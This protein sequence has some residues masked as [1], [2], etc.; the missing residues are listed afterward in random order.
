MGELALLAREATRLSNRLATIDRLLNA[1]APITGNGWRSKSSTGGDLF[2]RAATPRP[3][4]KRQPAA[5]FDASWSIFKYSD[6]QPRVPAGQHGGGQWTS[7]DGGGGISVRNE[8]ARERARTAI[9]VIESTVKQMKRNA[10]ADLGTRFVERVKAALG[11]LE[12]FAH[13]R[14]S[15]LWHRLLSIAAAAVHAVTSSID[16]IGTAAG[17][18]TLVGLTLGNAPVGL[19]AAVTLGGLLVWDKWAKRAATN[20]SKAEAAATRIRI[21]NLEAQLAEMHAAW[22]RKV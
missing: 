18:G 3:F 19:A 20:R 13:D 17:A 6:A 9:G 16:I 8:R 10:D 1:P 4:A 12:D 21:R 2:K 22:G 15:G 14:D 11:Y 5:G 7:G